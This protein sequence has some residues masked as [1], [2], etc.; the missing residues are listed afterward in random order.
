M[1]WRG[2]SRCQP[3]PCG[4]ARLDTEPMSGGAFGAKG[5]PLEPTSRHTVDG[6]STHGI[7]NGLQRFPGRQA[8]GDLLSLSQGQSQVK[9]PRGQGRRSALSTKNVRVDPRACPSRRAMPRI[10]SLRLAR[11]S[12][13]SRP[14]QPRKTASSSPHLPVRVIASTNQRGCCVDTLRPLRISRG[15][16]PQTGLA[17]V[18]RKRLDG[19]VGAYPLCRVPYEITR[20][21]LTTSARKLPRHGPSPM[22]NAVQN[23]EDVLLLCATVDEEAGDGMES[24]GSANDPL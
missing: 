8:P 16:K 11:S 2:S 21:T 9:A 20:S 6:G 19:S 23:V 4:A 13:R 24:I 12:P 18:A 1:V 14:S 15:G 10:A 22:R 7:G 3:E 5:P 17:D